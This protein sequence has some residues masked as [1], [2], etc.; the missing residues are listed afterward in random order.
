MARVFN[1]CFTHKGNSYTALVSVG[2]KP[3]DN[4]KVRIIS[5]EENIQIILPHGRLIFPTSEILQR[6]TVEKQKG[7]TNAVMNITD[8]ISLQLMNTAW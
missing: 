3:E 8:T 1:I 2:G 7:I 4:E 5:G 6:L